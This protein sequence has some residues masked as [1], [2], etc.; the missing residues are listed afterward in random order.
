[1]HGAGHRW[2]NR[3]PTL[4]LSG[5]HDRPGGC[6][7]LDPSWQDGLFWK[8]GIQIRSGDGR[9]ASNISSGNSSCTSKW[10]FL[11]VNSSLVVFGHSAC[12][13]AAS[14]EATEVHSF[15]LSSPFLASLAWNAVKAQGPINVRN[16]S[17]Y[18]GEVSKNLNHLRTSKSLKRKL[19]SWTV[20]A[21]TQETC[22][23]SLLPPELA[24]IFTTL[25]ASSKNFS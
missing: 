2:R 6:S 24:F 21:H 23:Y 12:K 10:P 14:G 1:M 9:A 16:R 15:S 8:G 5:L 17:F 18:L 22:S 11:H 3:K 7:V 13:L 20:H 4:L 19:Q 25:S